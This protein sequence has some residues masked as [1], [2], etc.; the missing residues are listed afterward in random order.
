MNL[1]FETNKGWTESIIDDDCEYDKFYRVAD[2]LQNEIGLT[3]T[4]KLDDFDTLYWDFDFKGSKLVHFYNIYEGT[5]IFPRA[6]KDATET[7]NQRVIEIGE[8]VFQKLIDLDWTQFDNGNTIGKTGSED[9][10]TILDIENSN[11]ARITQEKDCR[12]IPFAITLGIYGLMC[13][14]HFE[15]EL[16]KANEYV[17]DSKHRINRIFEMYDAPEDRQNEYWQTKL[18]KMIN[19]LAKMTS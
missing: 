8:L 15:S 5:T 19:D 16:Q 17:E 10:T 14:T 7:D 18:D 1:K 2:I 4:K 9:G 12:G 6:F 11:G 3:F 13:H